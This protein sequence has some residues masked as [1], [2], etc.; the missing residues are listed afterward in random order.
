[1]GRLSRCHGCGA[2]GAP[3][4]GP[5]ARLPARQHG[6]QAS[7]HAPEAAGQRPGARTLRRDER[8]RGL[9]RHH[10]GLARD[11]AH[12]RLEVV[13]EGGHRLVAVAGVLRHRAVEQR[14]QQRERPRIDLADRARRLVDHG[15][16]DFD[17]VAA[18]ERRAARDHL[19]E[20]DAEA[21]DVG[22]V[23]GDL[24][25]RLLGRAVA[26]RAVGHADLGDGVVRPRRR[27][28]LRLRVVGD[29]QLG[30]AEVEDARLPVRSHDDVGGLEVAVDDAGGV[31]DRERVGDLDRDR[32]REQRLERAARHVLLE[33]RALHVLQD[34]VVEPVRLADVVDRLDV[35]VVERG[36]ERRLA[37]EAAARRLAQGELRLQRLDHDGAREPQVLRLE[38][39][40]LA[41]VAQ[42][43]DDPVVR[44]R[45]AGAGD[46]HRW[47]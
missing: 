7:E 1:M 29:Q 25:A 30:E 9:G 42:R 31:S 2:A 38:R 40:R 37:L 32:Q 13:A 21:E 3:A 4:L 36:A 44:D 19:V 8:R 23:V 15:V 17:R 34:D 16:Q 6:A 12:Q 45:A 24:A 47:T 43:V 22:A 18:A 46:R 10:A 14:L 20:H 11:P 28:A 26:H 41:A 39:R 5:G 33:R 35:G 27:R